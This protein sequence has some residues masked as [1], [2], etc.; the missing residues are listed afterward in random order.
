MY[1][2]IGKHIH[3]YISDKHYCKMILTPNQL[4]SQDLCP[5]FVRC[6][7]G[8]QS[9]GCLKDLVYDTTMSEKKD[10][11]LIKINKWISEN[12]IRWPLFNTRKIKRGSSIRKSQ[13]KRSHTEKENADI[14]C[15]RSNNHSQNWSI[16]PAGRCDGNSASTSSQGVRISNSGTAQFGIPYLVLKK[17]KGKKKYIKY[18]RGWRDVCQ[19]KKYKK[20]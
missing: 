15:R 17:V 13:L 5:L 16:P 19:I 20:T 14:R 12:L 18:K 3:P 11:I 9:F 2:C 10:F 7:C 8:Q 6:R 1:L 4:A